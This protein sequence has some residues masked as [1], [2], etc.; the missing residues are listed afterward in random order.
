[1]KVNIFQGRNIVKRIFSKSASSS[2]NRQ[3]AS[4]LRLPVRGHTSGHI[5]SFKGQLPVEDVYTHCTVYTPP[6]LLLPPTVHS[7]IEKPCTEECV[8][9]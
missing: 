7:L 8:L 9:R 6:P 1:M 4:S 5:Y 2:A 3:A